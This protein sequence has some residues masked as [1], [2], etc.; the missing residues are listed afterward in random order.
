MGLNAHYQRCELK[1]GIGL[2]RHEI[3]YGGEPGGDAA[4][5]A[6]EG[7]KKWLC[8]EAEWRTTR[9]SSLHPISKPI[10][11]KIKCGD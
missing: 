10:Q 9:R 11:R 6:N 1:D 5:V 4:E 7:M 2:S 8:G 3:C